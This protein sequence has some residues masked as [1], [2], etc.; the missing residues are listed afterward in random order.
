MKLSLAIGFSVFAIVTGCQ[1][2]RT[3]EDSGVRSNRER[4]K[5]GVWV[6]FLV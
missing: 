4:R 3:Q 1:T 2:A 6:K 5:I